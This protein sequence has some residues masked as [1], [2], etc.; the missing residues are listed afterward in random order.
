MNMVEKEKLKDTEL[1]LTCH[2]ADNG[3]TILIFDESI[4]ALICRTRFYDEGLILSQEEKKELSQKVIDHLFAIISK[5][6]ST[7]WERKCDN[8]REA[9]QYQVKNKVS[10]TWLMTTILGIS[11]AEAE[12][13]YDVGQELVEFSD[14][15]LDDKDSTILEKIYLASKPL[16]DSM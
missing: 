16:I 4:D 2:T 1:N 6:N 14:F 7:N 5:R 3:N 13:R 11:Q 12:R 15:K 8:F 10:V 9:Y